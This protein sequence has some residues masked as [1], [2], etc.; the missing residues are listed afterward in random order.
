[1]IKK[2]SS[3]S[4]KK[5]LRAIFIFGFVIITVWGIQWATYARPPGYYQP[6][7]STPAN[8]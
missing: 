5:I 3:F 4:T 7:V 2:T 1:M 6:G 8:H